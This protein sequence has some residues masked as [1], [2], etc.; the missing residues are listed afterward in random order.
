MINKELVRQ[1]LTKLLQLEIG[2]RMPHNSGVC[3]ELG[4]ASLLQHP[5]TIGGLTSYQIVPKAERTPEYKWCYDKCFEWVNMSIID[6]DLG[7]MTKKRH[8]FVLHLLGKIDE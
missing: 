5:K 1:T 4:L 3:L 6:Y 8:E 2:S 7:T